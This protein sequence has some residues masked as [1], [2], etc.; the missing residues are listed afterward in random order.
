VDRDESWH[1]SH[2]FEMMVQPMNKAGLLQTRLD[3]AGARI[4]GELAPKFSAVR[5]FVWPHLE[6]EADASGRMGISADFGLSDPSSIELSI[7]PTECLSQFIRLSQ[8]ADG[9]ILEFAR[10]YGRLGECTDPLHPRKGCS[11]CEGRLPAQKFPMTWEPVALWRLES[12][13]LRGALGAWADLCAGATPDQTECRALQL[14]VPRLDADAYI[15][16]GMYSALVR[17]FLS[18]MLN[19]RDFWFDVVDDHPRFS[20]IMFGRGLH[21]AL[22]LGMATAV[23]SGGL[24]RCGICKLPYTPKRRPRSLVRDGRS[25]AHYCSSDCSLEGERRRQRSKWAS[26]HPPVRT[27][28]YRAEASAAGTE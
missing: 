11:R 4:D 28:R 27:S 13:V 25:E 18:A 2:R 26:S 3:L 10:R 24:Y 21:A 16:E 23:T 7:D 12:A 14:L 22:A 17:E 15:A 19:S 6:L 8:S 20:P 1:L 5:V 9:V